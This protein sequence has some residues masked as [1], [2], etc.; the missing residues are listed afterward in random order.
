[1]ILSPNRAE[2]GIAITRG[3]ADL[4]GEGGVI[5]R[6]CVKR[7]LIEADEV[8]FIDGDDHVPDSEQRADERM[9]PRLDQDALASVNQHDCELGVRGAGCHV[10]G[11]LLMARRI[12]HDE[13][14]PRGGKETVG[15]VNGDALLTLGLQSVDQKREIDILAGRAVARGILDQARHLVVED[16]F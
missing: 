1:M 16:Q 7:A 4:F 9:P 15:D 3:K 2:I 12:G 10:A 11:V 14:A 5:P 13:G 8:D 6:Q